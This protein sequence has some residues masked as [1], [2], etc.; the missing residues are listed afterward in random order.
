MNSIGPFLISCSP[1]HTLHILESNFCS[2]EHNRLNAKFIMLKK[3]NKFS[4]VLNNVWFEQ[5]ILDH[6]TKRQ[7]QQSARSFICIID[8]LVTW[9]EF[10]IKITPQTYIQKFVILEISLWK[11]CNGKLSHLNHS[12]KCYTSIWKEKTVLWNLSVLKFQGFQ[13][14]R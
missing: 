1:T 5:K 2:I 3:K 11:K 9:F 14:F 10:G 7:A 8:T 4:I 6:A 13:I 12:E